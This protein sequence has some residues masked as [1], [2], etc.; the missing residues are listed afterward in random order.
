MAKK[1]GFYKSDGA[2]I[3]G[4]TGYFANLP[5]KEIVKYYPP[6]N[7]NGNDNLNDG[8][9]GIDMQMRDDNK[10]KKTG[11]FPERY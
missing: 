9:T 5:D 4:S 8:I 3:S 1:R 7:Y 2:M 10:G 6:V 11:S